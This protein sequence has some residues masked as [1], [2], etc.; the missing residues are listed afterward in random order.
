MQRLIDINE[1]SRLLGIPK[2]SLYNLVYLRRL[3]F[4]KVG[5]SLRFDPDEVIQSLRHTPILEAAGPRWK[6]Q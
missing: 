1:L 3:P 5:R 4:F 2:G 6:G